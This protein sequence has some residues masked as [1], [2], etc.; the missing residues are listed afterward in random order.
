MDIIS[1]MH[2]AGLQAEEMASL[3]EVTKPTIYNWG[4]GKP[5]RSR[6]VFARAQKVCGLIARGIELGQLPIPSDVDR[7][8]RLEK[9]RNLL[10]NILRSS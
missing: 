4:K 10:L 3:C 2:S 1:L 7:L 8:K 6:A 5:P 9:I